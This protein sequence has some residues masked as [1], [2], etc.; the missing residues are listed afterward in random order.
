MLY[1]CTHMAT[2]RVKGFYI[3]YSHK[4]TAHSLIYEY[5]YMNEG[6][7]MYSLPFC[8]FAVAT[9]NGLSAFIRLFGVTEGEDVNGTAKF[10]VPWAFSL[11]QFAIKAAAVS[12]SFQRAAKTYLFGRGQ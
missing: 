5:L 10:C 11:E 7:S 2:V 1:S 3:V 8:T 6:L 4:R 9:P 12:A